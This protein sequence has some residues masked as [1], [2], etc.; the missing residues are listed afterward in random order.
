MIK[1]TAIIL[2][3]GKSK[4]AGTDKQFYKLS[5]KYIIQHTIDKFINIDEIKEIIIVL[6][7][8]N[9]KKYE[10]LFRN[11]KIKLTIGGSTRIQSLI[12]GSK[13]IKTN[14]DVIIVHDGARPFI[15]E[16]LIKEIIINSH[17]N[18]CIVP[19]IPLKDTI[20]EINT[21][22]LTVI[23]T[24]SRDRFFA[25]QT[26]QGYSKDIFSMIISSANRYK[27]LTDDSQIAEK[28][29]IKIKAIFGE[30]TNIKITTPIDFKIAEVIYEKTKKQ[31]WNS[32]WIWFWCT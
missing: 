32:C 28:L 12:N 30:E 16:K 21:K 29:K 15:S 26:P 10:S 20:K 17:K 13:Q 4:R 27:H 23:K 3:A 8:E 5:N 9:L 14:P 22:N 18:G 11:P 7:K 31:T 25:V 6:S 24:P 1:T 19:I 2:A